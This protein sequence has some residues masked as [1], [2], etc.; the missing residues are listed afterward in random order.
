MLQVFNKANF[1]LMWGVKWAFMAFSA[2][3]IV[4]S[5]V[6]MIVNGFNVGIDFAGGTAVQVR[7]ADPPPVDTIRTALESQGLGDV[8][9]QR[10]GDPKD[11]EI[12]VRVEAAP[13]LTP[14]GEEGGETSA[15]V[16]EALRGLVGSG[17]PSRIDLN[18]ATESAIRDWIAGRL[19]APADAAA[20]APDAAAMAKAIVAA[21]AAHGGLFTDAAEIGAIP[22]IDPAVAAAAR[23]Q[24]A[25]GRV[26]LRGVDFVGPTAGREL[27]RNTFW[28]IL[29]SVVGIL[30]YVWLR[31]HHIAWGVAAIIALVHDVV[32]ASG[33]MALTG[34]EFSLTVVA[35][36]LTILGYSI[37]DTIVIFDRIRENLRLY[38]DHDFEKVVNAS[39][40]QTLSRSV[41]T[42]LT[43]FIAVFALFLYGGEKLNPMSFCLL[44]GVVSGSYS[45]IFVAAALLVVAYQRLGPKYVKM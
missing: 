10:I 40:N 16:I 3:C 26:A 2:F 35:A 42:S 29:W 8:T 25:F 24:A 18:T 34:K 31:F 12:L 28:A 15:K 41:L 27:L 45:T 19:P 7:F 37:N 9:L 44:V 5:V 39:V 4:I 1:R 23:D 13:G 33:A 21:R 11:N 38:R 20:P 36:L 22:G 30:I 17:D 43:V 6:V 14:G 32:I